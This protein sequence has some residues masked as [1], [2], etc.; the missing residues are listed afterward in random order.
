M[1]RVDILVVGGGPAGSSVA[2]GLRGS[3]LHVAVMDKSPFPRD[4]TCAG[5]ITPAVLRSL[6]VDPDSYAASGRTLQPIWGFRVGIEGAR[7]SAATFDRVISYGIRRCEWDHFLLERSGAEL[8]LGEPLRALERRGNGWL[9]NGSVHA[10]LLIGAGG[11]FCPVRRML[12]P[13]AA[14]EPAIAAQEIEFELPANAADPSVDPGV[15]ELRFTPA[16]DGYGWVF[17]KG[18]YLNVGLGVRGG[19]R[20]GER[21]RALREAWRRE[22]LLPQEVPDDVRGHAYLLQGESRRPLRGEQVAFVGDSA[23]FAYP[24]SGE[25]IRPAV[26]S[27]LLLASELR[28]AADFTSAAALAGYERLAWMRFGPRDPIPSARAFLPQALERA[29]ARRLFAWPWFAREVIVRDWFVHERLP[30]VYLAPTVAR[31]SW[32]VRPSPSN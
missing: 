8:Q 26:E 21:F 1:R 11:H 22:G 5:W 30:P 15:P 3:G 23:G 25:G 27:G 28:K 9:A 17:R 4:K 20:L 31:T 24:R 10:R 16:L 18:R 6:A 19:E 29:I 32:H 7:A 12:A 14:R 13:A 2:W